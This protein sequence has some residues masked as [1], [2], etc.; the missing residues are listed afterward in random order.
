MRKFFWLM[1]MVA[2][3][4]VVIG[5]PLQA[6]AKNKKQEPAAP[7]S[8]SVAGELFQKTCKILAA[9]KGYSFQA[10]VLMDVIFPDGAKIQIARNMDVVVQRPKSFKIVTTGDE[11]QATSVFDGK[12]FTLALLHKKIYGQIPAAMETDALVAFLSEK[13]DLDSPL[14]DLLLNDTCG[15]MNATTASYVGKGYVGKILC[16]HLFFQ[17]K[18]IDWQIWLEDNDKQL[19]RKLVITEKKLPNSPQFTAFINNWQIV[20]SPASAF[21]FTA[22]ADLSRDGN[23]FTHKKWL[24]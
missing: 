5:S 1:T 24:Q 19:P 14:G 7:V 18:D 16:H 23:L 15:K 12:T 8:E 17:S 10:E 13:F 6:Q 11:G 20:D 9:L 22:P 2:V 3:L 21:A 4:A